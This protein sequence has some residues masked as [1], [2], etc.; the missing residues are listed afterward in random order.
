MSLRLKILPRAEADAQSIFDF[1]R[2]RSPEGANAWWT[3]FEDAA[4][5]AIADAT[6]F[7]LAPENESLNLELR[8]VLFKTKRG[9]TY[10]FVFTIVDAELRILRV[11]G[12]GQPPLSLDEVPSEG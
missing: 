11:R 1:I 6:R 2:E 8:Q 9:R 10:R 3:A 5:R 12:P 4:H 7:A